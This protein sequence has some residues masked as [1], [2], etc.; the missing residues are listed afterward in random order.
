MKL[1]DSLLDALVR[2]EGDSLVMHVGEKPYVVT[3][4]ASMNAY[5]GPLAWGQVELSSKVLTFEAMSS[6][7]PQILPPD[8]Q[9]AL[10]EFGAVEQEIQSPPGVVDRFTI[11][12]AR[13]GEDVWLEVRRR[14]I[15][16]PEL[17]ASAEA[18]AAEPTIEPEIAR[19]PESARAT[20]EDV[21]TVALSG[22]MSDVEMSVD[23]GSEAADRT[24]EIREADEDGHIELVAAAGEHDGQADESHQAEEQGAEASPANVDS[25]VVTLPGQEQMPLGTVAS[26]DIQIVDDEPQGVPT[27]EEVDALLATAA[28]AL[29]TPDANVDE[30]ADDEGDRVVLR[31]VRARG[32]RRRR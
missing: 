22:S 32:R 20:D 9:V 16:V 15:E 6:M 11:V 27:D 25:I 28:A 29:L 1:L 12:A 21:E 13:G 3:A 8:Q 19:E 2:L 5:R 14:P 31:Q 10:D 17:E 24:I 23:V 30:Y 4:S 26:D 18:P 7:L